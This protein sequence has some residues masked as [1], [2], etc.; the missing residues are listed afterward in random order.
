[1]HSLQEWTLERG[2]QQRRS[3]ALPGK[4]AEWRASRGRAPPEP[5]IK[6]MRLQLFIATLRVVEPPPIKPEATVGRHLSV[7]PGR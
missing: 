4:S 1:M 6:P 7:W 5:R 3:A 2:Q